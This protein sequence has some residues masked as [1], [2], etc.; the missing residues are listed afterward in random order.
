MD[1]NFYDETICDIYHQVCE[2][3]NDLIK[4]TREEEKER[5]NFYG[6]MDYYLSELKN[7][8]YDDEKIHFN[9]Q[10]IREK[11]GE[12]LLTL[13][14]YNQ[15]HGFIVGFK[16]AFYIFNEVFPKFSIKN[17]LALAD[18]EIKKG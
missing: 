13:E 8:K 18:E 15:I 17:A 1:Y 5:F 14:Y 10:K 16:Y 2:N 6:E 11:M 12:K 4:L 3:H 7:V 9:D